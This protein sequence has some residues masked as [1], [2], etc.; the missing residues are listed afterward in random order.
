[1]SGGQRRKHTPSGNCEER[2]RSGNPPQLRMLRAKRGSPPA[3]KQSLPPPA[4]GR[5]RR[6]MRSEQWH[7]STSAKP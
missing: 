2:Q 4:R 5:L 6:G 7:Q 1:M 3:Q